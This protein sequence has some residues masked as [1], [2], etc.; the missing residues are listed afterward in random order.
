MN[1]LLVII[2]EQF[3][4]SLESELKL[5]LKLTANKSVGYS[6]VHIYLLAP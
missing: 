1:E 2:F 6:G 4:D 5:S 3:Y